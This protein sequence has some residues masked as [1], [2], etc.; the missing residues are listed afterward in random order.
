MSPA[1][2]R[3]VL[4][5]LED[6][7][8]P[9][10]PHTS[11]GRVPTEAAFRL[12]I[13]ALMRV[14]QLSDDETTQIREW[15]DEL[16]PGR[17]HP[18]RDGKLLS[19]LTGAPAV[20]VRSRAENG[21]LI[22]VRFI[23]ARPSELLACSSFRRHGREPI[24]Q[25]RASRS[26]MPSSS[27]FT[28][29]SRTPSRGGRS[30]RFATTFSGR[31][32]NNAMS[33]ALRVSAWSLMS[34]AMEGAE[35]STELV[36]KGSRACSIGRSSPAPSTAEDTLRA[37]EDRERLVGLLDR[38]LASR[39][40]QVFLGEETTAAVGV[41][42]SW[43][44]R[45]ITARTALQAGPWASSGRRASDYPTVVPLVGATADAMSAALA[46]L[47]EVAR[48]RGDTDDSDEDMRSYRVSLASDS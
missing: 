36:I 16:P 8:L 37:L 12:F 42:V 4:A 35:R 28:T 5:D 46:R 34:A 38:T 2:I 3:N 14:R 22:K 27:A 48:A 11:A 41:P 26:A 39:R 1:T 20:L 7:G 24:H 45:P 10:Q 43:L 30:R 9:G 6:A 19:D 33:F 32:T 23:Q 44:P 40:V 15:F 17:R 13:D 47:R 18:A 21:T 31:S 25:R 29:C